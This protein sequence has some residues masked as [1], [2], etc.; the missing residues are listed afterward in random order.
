[1]QA[2]GFLN[3]HSPLRL[4]HR[5]SVRNRIVV[6]PMASSTAT[7]DGLATDTTI[8]HYSRLAQ[9]GAGL[10]IVEYSFVHSSGRSEEHQLGISTDAHIEGLS[11]ISKVIHQSGA[12]AGIQLTHGG[13]KSA[14]SLTGGILMGA[15]AIPV[16]VKDNQLEVPTPMTRDDIEQWKDAFVAASDRAVQ[17]G[18]DLIELHSAHGYGLNQMLS[19]ITNQR[20]D[21][22]GRDLQGRMRLLLEI[23]ALIRE[24]HPMLLISVRMPGQDF[25]ENGLKLE[26]TIQVAQ[27]LEKAGVDVLHI[28]SGVGGWR[29]PSN[30]SGIEGYLVAEAAVIQSKVSIPVIG[31]GG[32]QTAEYI[33]N[34]IGAGVISLAAVGR[35]ILHDPKSFK[36]RVLETL[37]LSGLSMPR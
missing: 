8:E 11:K 14:K 22:Y 27:A 2:V 24:R 3:R 7:T 33:D 28:S 9:A 1:M 23:V 35:G 18:F 26:D 19:P 6:P 5:L 10:L 4:N 16:P 34:A 37:E 25:F 20:Q 31:V 32:I 21:E 30:R 29:G 17:S 12:L 15:S 13:G 36:E